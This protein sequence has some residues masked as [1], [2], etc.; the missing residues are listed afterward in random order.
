M[1]LKRI[2]DRNLNI[3]YLNL[4]R[5]KCKVQK[6]NDYSLYIFEKINLSR[7]DIV[8]SRDSIFDSVQVIF[9]KVI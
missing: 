4:S 6:I 9:I 2:K 7:H 1:E 5:H 3:R 8:S